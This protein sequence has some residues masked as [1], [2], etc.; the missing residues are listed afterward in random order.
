MEREVYVFQLILDKCDLLESQMKNENYKNTKT[1][2]LL[3]EAL[4]EKDKYLVHLR[5]N[6]DNSFTR[7]PDF[8]EISYTHLNESYVYKYAI[9]RIIELIEKSTIN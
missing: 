3:K 9:D 1:L 8:K 2:K 5:D 7:H 6:C 4:E